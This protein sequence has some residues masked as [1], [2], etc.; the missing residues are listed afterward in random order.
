MNVFLKIKKSN[1]DLIKT[2]IKKTEW[3]EPSV[4]NKKLLFKKRES[5]GKNEGNVDIKTITFV[6]GYSKDAEKLIVEVKQIRLV[7]F[8]RNIEIPE[9]NFKALEGQFSIEISLGNIVNN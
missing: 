3:R 2:G 6:N 5:D 9:D 7:R 8:S 4:Y 1:L